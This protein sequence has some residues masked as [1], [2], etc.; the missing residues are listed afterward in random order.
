MVALDI[1]PIAATAW[2]SGSTSVTVAYPSNQENDRLYFVI[3]SKQTTAAGSTIATPTNWTLVNQQ[4]VGATAVTPAN[5]VGSTRIAVFSRTVPAGGLSGDTGAIAVLNGN[6]TLATI[7]TFRAAGIGVTWSEAVAGAAN[8]ATAATAIGGAHASAVAWAPK[9]QA[10]VICSTADD[11][12]DPFALDSI[13]ATGI[14]F[15]TIT[16]LPDPGVGTT[17]GFDTSA[18][19]WNVPVTAGTST[20]TPTTA[21]TQNTSETSGVLA[22]RVR[23]DGTAHQNIP[24]GLVTATS[25]AQALT[26]RRGYPIGIALRDRMGV[27]A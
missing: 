11:T 4:Q 23:A 13:T 14:T 6:S 12:S 1:T 2:A 26:R 5:G 21:G 18:C 7:I 24:V 10:L 15:G 20:Q 19:A 9:D 25:T 8:R 22:I 27:A 3:C 16:K 17:T